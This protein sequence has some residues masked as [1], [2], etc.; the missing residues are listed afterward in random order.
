MSL[1]SDLGQT[2]RIITLIKQN[3]DELISRHESPLSLGLNRGGRLSFQ[4][5][6][7]IGSWFPTE[8][9]KLQQL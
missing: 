3:I 6:A 8:S 4:V 1:R 2:Y 7:M 5:L 9:S